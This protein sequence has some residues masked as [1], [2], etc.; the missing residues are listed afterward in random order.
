[1]P[2]PVLDRAYRGDLVRGAT[3]EIGYGVART[4][5]GICGNEAHRGQT[6]SA[7]QVARLH[8]RTHRRHLPA[9]VERKV[10]PVRQAT[11]TPRHRASPLPGQPGYYYLSLPAIGTDGS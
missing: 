8:K 5:A 1:M 7:G 9:L 2:A 10:P 11:A 3:A 4:G 6:R